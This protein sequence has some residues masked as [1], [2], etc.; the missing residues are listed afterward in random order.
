MF[1]RRRESNF[2]LK[3]TWFPSCR[4]RSGLQA[5]TVSQAACVQAETPA[6]PCAGDDVVLVFNVAGLRKEQ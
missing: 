5:R 2:M 3:N 1:P 4:A 6:S